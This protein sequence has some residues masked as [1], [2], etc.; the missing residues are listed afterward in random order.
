M[1]QPE[2]IMGAD[3]AVLTFYIVPNTRARMR[4][5]ITDD[6]VAREAFTPVV[7]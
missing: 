1:N 6:V 3:L 7:T 2:Q 5:L 4:R